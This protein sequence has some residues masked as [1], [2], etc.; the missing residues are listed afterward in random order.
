MARIV[1]NGV[2][3][4]KEDSP[5]NGISFSFSLAVSQRCMYTSVMKIQIMNQARNL[6]TSYATLTVK[7]AMTAWTT[8]KSF[9][10]KGQVR[11]PFS[12]AYGL[13]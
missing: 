7:G 9:S 5:L 13:S 12:R 3:Q 11:M 10:L 6:K 4:Q 1:R 8:Q 2:F